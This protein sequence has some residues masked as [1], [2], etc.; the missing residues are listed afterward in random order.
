MSAGQDLLILDGRADS[1]H[2]GNGRATISSSATLIIEMDP[3]NG[4]DDFR[5]LPGRQLIGTVRHSYYIGL[6][7][8]TLI[9]WSH[10]MI[11]G[12]PAVEPG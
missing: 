1:R 9:A 12:L 8:R 4:P 11:T 6:Q 3:R 7:A 5:W 10:A 2:D